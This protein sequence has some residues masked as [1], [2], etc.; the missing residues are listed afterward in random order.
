ME[1]IKYNGKLYFISI[2]DIN[3]NVLFPK[4][5]TNYFTKYSYE[6]NIH[7]RVCF[8]KTIEKCLMALSR[9]C[10][11]L[12]FNVYGVDD[13]NNYQIYK[14]NTS[15]VPDSIITEELWILTPVK[16]KYIGKIKCTSSDSN[17]GY[18]FNYGDKTAK[19]YKWKYEWL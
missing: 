2:K 3:N 17:D 5:P 6:D 8:C 9:N 10:K 19:L 11:D 1:K 14:P 18:I 13:I 12:I 4:I 7:K 15:E 16:L